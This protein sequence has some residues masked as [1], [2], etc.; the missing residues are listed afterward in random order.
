MKHTALPVGVHPALLGASRLVI[1]AAEPIVEHALLWLKLK[2]SCSCRPCA[3]TSHP[4]AA[5]AQSF[6]RP[7]HTLLTVSHALQKPC[8][9][10]RVCSWVAYSPVHRVPLLVL[11]R[12][13]AVLALDQLR[14]WSRCRISDALHSFHGSIL[15]CPGQ[16]RVTKVESKISA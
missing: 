7:H 13:L 5:Q 4:A 16:L 6:P 10:V 9:F 11:E 15:P 12:R 1:V 3:E 2:Y 14:R 8:P